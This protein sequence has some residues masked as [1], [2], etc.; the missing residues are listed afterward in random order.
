MTPRV[1]PL[2]LALLSAAAWAL[3]L[4]ILAARPELFI[5]AIPLALVL[6]TLAIRRPAPQ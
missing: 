4:G 1:T 3:P 2:G 5:A 6:L